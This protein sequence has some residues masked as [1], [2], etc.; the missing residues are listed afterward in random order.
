MMVYETGYLP[1]DARDLDC[2]GRVWD[3]KIWGR[4]WLREEFVRHFVV[5]SA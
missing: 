2:V 1:V 5:F 3:T 4:F